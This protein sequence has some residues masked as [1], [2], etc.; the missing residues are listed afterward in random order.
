M[1]KD[2][3]SEM[4]GGWFVGDFA[5]VALR[6]DACEVA[7]K[8]YAAGDYDTWHYH[9]I[10]TE[11]TVIVTGEV[12]MNGIRHKAG[13]ILVIAPGE[14]TDFRCLTPVTT[15]VVKVPGAKNDKYLR[16]DE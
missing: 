10:A 12:E 9:K 3:L 14:G 6:T 1:H 2:Q 16:Q 5:P 7:V 13:D 8:H 11:V 15:V 4:I